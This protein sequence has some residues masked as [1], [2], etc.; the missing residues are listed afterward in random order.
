MEEDGCV[1][2]G[3]V[4]SEVISRCGCSGGRMH[5]RCLRLW[6][7]KRGE[8]GLVCEVCGRG[9]AGVTLRCIDV[10]VHPRACASVALSQGGAYVFV[11][12]IRA[13][14][15][16]VSHAA[17]GAPGHEQMLLWRAALLYLYTWKATQLYMW[18]MGALR[19]PLATRL[20]SR[21][22]ILVPN[23]SRPV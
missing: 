13:W 20:V 16:V 22:W 18:Y 21:R 6:L 5:D 14:A 10:D 15:D 23:F 12:L 1:V 4:G 9:R 17:Y 3:G 7:A 19:L 8:K 2:C 11:W